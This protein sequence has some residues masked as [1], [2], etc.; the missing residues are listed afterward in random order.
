M[1]KRKRDGMDRRE[2]NRVLLYTMAD[3]FQAEK[4]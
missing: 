4:G 3:K 2:P 1:E